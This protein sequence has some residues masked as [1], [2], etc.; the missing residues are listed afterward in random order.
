MR[1]IEKQGLESLV[2]KERKPYEPPRVLYSEKL[3][4]ATNCEQTACNPNVNPFCAG[5]SDT[6][7][8]FGST[9]A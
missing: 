6:C 4:V 2:N 1:N 8:A 5:P 9:P 7:L 3:N